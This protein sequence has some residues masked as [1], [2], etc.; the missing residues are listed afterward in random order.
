MQVQRVDLVLGELVDVPLDLVDPEEVPRDVEH[1][2]AV[3]EPRRVGDGPAGHRPRAAHGQQLAQRL[4]RVEEPRRGAGGQGDPRGRG[5]QPVPLGPQPGGPPVQAQPDAVAGLPVD[6]GQ[7]QPAGPAQ[8][9]GEE[10]ADPA[11]LRA[12]GAGAAGTDDG[13]RAEGVPGAAGAGG[14]GRRQEPFVGG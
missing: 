12:G 7:R 3:R 11:D 5:L 6:H 1:R 4:P 10:F 14:G 9:P 8:L 13:A 2:A